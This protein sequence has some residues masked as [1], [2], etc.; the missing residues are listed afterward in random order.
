V[1]E[2]PFQVN[3]LVQIE[4]FGLPEVH[5]SNIIARVTREMEL[6]FGGRAHV[7]EARSCPHGA[8]GCPG[9]LPDRKMV[10]EEVHS[11]GEEAQV[12]TVSTQEASTGT[13]LRPIQ[14]HMLAMRLPL[15]SS[16]TEGESP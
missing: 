2:K 3:L 5:R 4:G 15:P 9:Y 13:G 10:S 6:Q 1:R 7:I 12:P 14:D 16:S 8:G 11:V